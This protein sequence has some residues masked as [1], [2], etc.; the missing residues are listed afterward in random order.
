LLQKFTLTLTRRIQISLNSY[1]P[2]MFIE[3]AW[4]RGQ[5]C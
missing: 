1:D 5:H 3:T 2:M 4:R